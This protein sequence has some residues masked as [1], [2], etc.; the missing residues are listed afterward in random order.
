MRNSI[1]RCSEKLF[2]ILRTLNSELLTSPRKEGSDLLEH[3]FCCP[4]VSLKK[5]VAFL[6][7]LFAGL[8]VEKEAS[9]LRKEFFFAR[10]LDSPSR[11]NQTAGDFREMKHVGTE[12][13][14]LSK[15]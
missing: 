4:L 15:E 8:L 6:S 10:Y 9:Q 1:V 3:S 13:D 12:E 14:A 7:Y 11:R 5:L 2:L